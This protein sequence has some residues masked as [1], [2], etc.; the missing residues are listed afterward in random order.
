MSSYWRGGAGEPINREVSTAMNLLVGRSA[1]L[2]GSA[3]G[4]SNML[5]PR[6]EDRIMRMV[7]PR[8]KILTGKEMANVVVACLNSSC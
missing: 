2:A 7:F 6:A 8:D 3:I 5:A 4:S 1:D